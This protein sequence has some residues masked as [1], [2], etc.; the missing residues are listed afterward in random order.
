MEEKW[1]LTGELIVCQISL[2]LNGVI[3]CV[4]FQRVFIISPKL[5]F[6]CYDVIW[7]RKEPARMVY[8]TGHGP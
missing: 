3:L 6:E 8:L 2:F 1:K 5:F 4:V 7:C